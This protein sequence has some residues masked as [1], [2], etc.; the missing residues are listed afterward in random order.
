MLF[1]VVSAALLALS[2]PKTEWSVLAWFAFV[3]FMVAL[4]GKRPLAAFRAGYLFGLVFF[5]AAFYWFIHVTYAGTAALLLYLA[6]YGGLFGFLYALFSRKAFVAR[7][8]LIP[9]SWVVLEFIRAHMIT[10]FSWASLGHS[11]YANI[12]L[13][14]IADITG[15]AGV[16]FVVMM[17]NVAIKELIGMR[18]R[19]PSEALCRE[20]ARGVA[21]VCLFVVGS[22]GYGWYR[23]NQTMPSAG[24]LDV[25]VIQPNIPQEIK[26][27]DEARVPILEKVKRISRRA[28][29][30]RPD[31]I[32]WPETSFPGYV[33][34]FPELFE[35][36]KDFT[37]SIQAPI[38]LGL[39]TRIGDAYYN[40]AAMVSRDGEMTVQ[41]DKI[42][43]VPFGE[44][45]PLRS[46]FPFLSGLVPIGDFTP[47]AQLTMFPATKNDGGA[48]PLGAF[49]VLICF[50]DTMSYLPRM[51]T[52][53]G[54]NLLVNI[55]NDAWFQDTAAPFLHMIA[56]VFCAV[57]NRRGLVR[58][59]NTGVSC[60]INSYGRV[61]N[62]VR[63]TT[64]AMTYV[65]GYASETMALHTHKTFYTK[66][67]DVFTYICF[68]SILIGAIKRR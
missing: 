55:T 67:G 57:E 33:W 34:E 43:L 53:A 4:D 38:V 63:D 26:W 68:G 40:T 23:L 59:A 50:E 58:A 25:A 6:V 18:V 42:H 51:F 64:G 5:T 15:V 31:V 11:Q 7:I 8:F 10:G 37:E 3:P 39:V 16:S 60:F 2:F 61:V 24:T 13:I 9:S 19:P 41:H 1:A 27:L 29:S 65:S 52:A 54:A 35:D 66:Y 28:A 56:S 46:V 12:A 45:I 20:L 21:I 32:I 36:I 17:A 48:Q 44:Y 14:Q 47:G 22:Y 49:S 30:E 62:A